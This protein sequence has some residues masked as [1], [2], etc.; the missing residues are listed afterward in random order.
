MTRIV[1]LHGFA[2]GPRSSKALYF[3]TLLEGAGASVEIP[4]LADGDFEHLT[5]TAQFDVIDRAVAGGPVALVGSSLG[6]YLAALYAARRPNV[7][8]IVLLAPA[9]GFAQRWPE[10]L[11]PAA[12]AAWHR[13]GTIDVFHYAD[14]CQRKLGYQFLDDGQR[15]EAD[16]D[17][18]QPALIFHGT[19]DD[20]VPVRY[21]EEF[22]AN[23]PNAT[24]EIL[25]A[26][27]DL[28]NVLDYMAPK[29]LRFLTD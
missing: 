11:G 12:V 20:T 21:S 14:N 7:E 24:L 6:G 26:G 17:F 9:F 10:R 27:H 2:S 23:H 29:I 13:A 1:Y 28:L 22:A 15:F 18:A 5:I 19:H 16:P 3:R 4:D 25:D 8:R